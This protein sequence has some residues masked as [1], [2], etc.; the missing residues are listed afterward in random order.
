MIGFYLPF[1]LS[2]PILAGG[3]LRMLIERYQKR[4]Q[5]TDEQKKSAER[6]GLLFASGLI[7]GEALIGILLAIPIIIYED[8]RALAQI[9][10]KTFNTYGALMAIP[11]IILLLGVAVWFYYTARKPKETS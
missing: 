4:K 3:I 8:K 2:V 9:S 5:M 7:T 1:E 10:E 6:T 11:G